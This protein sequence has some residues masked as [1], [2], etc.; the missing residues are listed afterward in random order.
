MTSR[1]P[2]VYLTSDRGNVSFKLAKEDDVV[3]AL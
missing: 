2:C 1:A 3:N